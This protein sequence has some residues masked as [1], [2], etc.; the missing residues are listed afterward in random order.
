[1]SLANN[2]VLKQHERKILVD[3]QE[4]TDIHIDACQ[5][6]LKYKFPH[7]KGLFSTLQPLSVGGWTEYIQ[8]VMAIIG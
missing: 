1:M 5:A 4:L 8:I 7:I 2:I 6:L 3:G